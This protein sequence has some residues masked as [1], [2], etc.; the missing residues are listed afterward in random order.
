MSIHT[1]CYLLTEFGTSEKVSGT[2]MMNP[3]L[4]PLEKFSEPLE[5]L[6]DTPTFNHTR[7]MQ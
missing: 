7:V 6:T 2:F 1:D 4:E 3:E 5:S